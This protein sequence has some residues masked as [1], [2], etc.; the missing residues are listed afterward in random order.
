MTGQRKRRSSFPMTACFLR[1]LDCALL[2]RSVGY[3]RRFLNCGLLLSSLQSCFQIIITFLSS[4]TT[5]HHL[6]HPSSS[7]LL[8][9]ALDGFL[10]TQRPFPAAPIIAL[11]SSQIP[12]CIITMAT[13]KTPIAT[14][15]APQSSHASPLVSPFIFGTSC[16]SQH[17]LVVFPF[18]QRYSY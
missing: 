1:Q 13:E 18:P 10:A 7:P 17:D 16:F 8:Y 9:P 5:C 11:N 4:T 15:V 14:T 2:H 3:L 6:H 12:H